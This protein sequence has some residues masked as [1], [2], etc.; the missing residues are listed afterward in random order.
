MEGGEDPLFIARRLIRLASEDIGLADTHALVQAVACYQ[1]CHNIGM[2]ECDVILA[3]C[4]AYLAR[5]PKS[6]AVYRAYAAARQ[7]ATAT[8]GEPV[9][10][11]LRN[12]PTKLMQDLS[13]GKGYKYSPE[14]QWQE[15]QEYFPAI[16]RGRDYFSDSK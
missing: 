12:A 1:A 3:Q 9:P 4:V 6:V 16:L 10:L 8:A 2:P 5:A 7:D 15:Q 14:Y 13:Y 11:H